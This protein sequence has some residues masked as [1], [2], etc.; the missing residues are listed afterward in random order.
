[1]DSLPVLTGAE[2]RPGSR[3]P[4]HCAQPDPPPLAAILVEVA[5]AVDT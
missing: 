4:V 1:M 3:R 2:T 5:P